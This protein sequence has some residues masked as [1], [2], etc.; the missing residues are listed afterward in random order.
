MEVAQKLA[1]ERYEIFDDQR[2]QSELLTTDE[3]D[4]RQIEALEKKN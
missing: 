2:K 4:L 3:D 1:S